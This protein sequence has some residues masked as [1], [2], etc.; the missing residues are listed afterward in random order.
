MIERTSITSQQWAL[1][2]TP[3]LLLLTTF[4]TYN[5]LAAVL[6]VKLG[7]FGGF[8]FYWIIWCLALPYWVLKP[9]SL[10]E[11]FRDV[12]PRLGRPTWLGAVCLVVLPIFAYVFYFPHALLHATLLIIL[13]SIPLA[14]VNATMEEVLWRG[15]YVTV[16][17]RHVVAGYLYLAVG[18]GF[19]HIAPLSIVPSTMRGGSLYFAIFAV[20]LGLAFGWVALSTGS[21][22]WTTVSHALLDFA[23]LGTLI[24]FT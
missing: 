10:R 22:R 6:G 12:H 21:I 2:I 9:R 3:P 13:T 23:G 15:T 4:L 7:Y 8:C 11:L 19:W 5:G 18:F 16:F 1:L 20:V 17:P 14:I 24:Y